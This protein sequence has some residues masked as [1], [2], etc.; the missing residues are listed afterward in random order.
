MS[1]SSAGGVGKNMNRIRAALFLS[2]IATLLMSIAAGTG[3]ADSAEVQKE[4]PVRF[5]AAFTAK[6]FKEN[7]DAIKSEVPDDGA[8]RI[9]PR[10]ANANIRTSFPIPENEQTYAE[11]VV[12]ARLR[13][14]KGSAAGVGMATGAGDYAAYV[15]PDGRGM[16]WY[17]D[18]KKSE[19]T[20][21]F[22]IK[23]FA[24]PAN[25][26][27]WRDANG[28]VILRING[29][30]AAVRLITVDLKVSDTSPVKSV[31]FATRSKDSSGAFAVYEAIAVEGWGARGPQG[32][33][34]SA[35]D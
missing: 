8:Y 17:S 29:A 19:W 16:L 28:S 5:R 15:Y 23:N 3:M 14:S 25:I 12:T 11:W 34:N 31:F 21:D 7:R 20:S 22:T 9:V 32:I 35:S 2:A 27:L 6:D 4:P 26:S 24:F 10:T 33:E 18:G 30:V 1:L 13:N